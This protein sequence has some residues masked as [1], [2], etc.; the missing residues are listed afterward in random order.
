MTENP[1]VPERLRWLDTLSSWLDNRFRIPFTNIRF[2]LDA[3]IGLVPYLGDMV[4]FG[5]SAILIIFMVRYGASGRVM[6][7]MVGNI[8]LDAL[9]GAIPLLGD[10]FDFRFR[11]NRRN[12]ELLRSHYATGKHQ[13]S[14][15]PWI[16]LLLLMLAVLFFLLLWL[17]W[18]AGKWVVS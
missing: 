17:I 14:A 6:M 10:I 2:G 18:E 15:W 13:G 1:P 16:L 7:L 5:M 4:S 9:L 12:F 3:L 11:A 8:A